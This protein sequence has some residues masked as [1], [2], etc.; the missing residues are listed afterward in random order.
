MES[1]WTSRS[2]CEILRRSANSSWQMTFVACSLKTS[3]KHPFSHDHTN[4]INSKKA[5]SKPCEG[6]QSSGLLLTSHLFVVHQTLAHPVQTPSEKN[7]IKRLPEQNSP[8]RRS[9]FQSGEH[10][11]SQTRNQWTTKTYQTWFWWNANLIS[12]WCDE[13]HQ[14]AGCG[15][16]ATCWQVS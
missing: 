6:H 12:P 8:H 1:Y 15:C 16:A 14:T 3:S 9:S 10:Q 13:L 2:S 7:C 5:T 11:R 4:W